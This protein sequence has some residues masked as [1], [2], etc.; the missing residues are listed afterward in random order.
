[1]KLKLILMTV[2]IIT[3]GLFFFMTRESVN[4]RIDIALKEQVK[5]LKIHYDLTK[6]YF[7]TDVASI[8]DNILNNKKVKSI[9]AKAQNASDDDKKILREEL[10]RLLLPTYKRL[11]TRG[12][13]QFQFVFTDNIIFKDAQTK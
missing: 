5:E 3:Y 11:Q 2:F 12:I 6:D 4:E 13:L 10:Y 1:M 7:L 9:F 8:K